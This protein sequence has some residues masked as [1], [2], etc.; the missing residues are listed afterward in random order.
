MA[1]NIYESDEKK[2]A[3]GPFV[4]ATRPAVHSWLEPV[5]KS[6]DRTLNM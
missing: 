5:E 3:R 4:G 2:Q 6:V 1:P